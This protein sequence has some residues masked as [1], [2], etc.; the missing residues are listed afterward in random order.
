M[1]DYIGEIRIFAGTYAPDHWLFCQG[2]TLLTSQYDV[3]YSVIGTTFGGNGRDNFMLPDLRG[4]CPVSP[5]SQVI[6][7]YMMGMER[8]YLT[9]ATLP[10]HN[11]TAD[12]QLNGTL[13]CNNNLADHTSPVDNT[14]G[15]FKDNIDVYNSNTPDADMHDQTATINGTINVG[16]AGGGNAH[17]NRQPSLALN[18]IICFQGIY[19]LRW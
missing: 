11:H 19:P 3:L 10:V 1:D 7:G 4:R 14:L 17:E 8:T 15:K 12:I 18:Y 9:T 13:R 16:L 2:Q 5:G 6:A